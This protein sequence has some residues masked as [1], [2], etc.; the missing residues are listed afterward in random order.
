MIQLMIVFLLI[1]QPQQSSA[2]ILFRRRRRTRL[3]WVNGIGYNL[4]HMKQAQPII[5]KMFG[6]KYVEFCH[7]P[8]SMST[9]DDLIGYLGD[10]TQAGSQKYLG[11]ITNEVNL[12]VT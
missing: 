6:G 2:I 10:L 4:Q 8:T 7:N 3:T 1:Q 11:R 12:L 9:E 5:S